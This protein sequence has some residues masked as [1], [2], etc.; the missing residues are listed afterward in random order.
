M[1][2]SDPSALFFKTAI[3][4]RL[5][6]F[7]SVATLATTAVCVATE[8]RAAANG[9]D[10][11][12]MRY[13]APVSP[14]WTAEPASNTFAR[15]FVPPQTAIMQ[16]II[17][18]SVY[19]PPLM[20]AMASLPRKLDIILGAAPILGTASM[21]NPNDP[22][23]SDSG[24]NETASGQIYNADDWTAAIRTDLR[25]Q[26]GG[27]RFG[28]NY[29]PAFALVQ[30][31]N[32]QAIVRINDIGPLKAGRIIDLNTRAMRYFDPTLQRG[33]LDDVRV[34][35]LSGEIWAVGPVIQEPVNIASFDPR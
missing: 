14:D 11:A 32:K 25:A 23:D 5:L 10:F 17:D 30:S 29:R 16:E 1:A 26:F 24:N 8:S 21:Y 15:R 31:S 12:T 22:N 13:L 34:L 19:P 35:P 27:V 7:I 6:R 20:P 4:V 9:P 18:R 3:R 28:K 33:L 2:F